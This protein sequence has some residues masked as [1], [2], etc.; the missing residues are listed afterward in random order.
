VFRSAD[1][2]VKGGRKTTTWLA[3]LLALGLGFSVSA[4][5]IV[6]AATYVGRVSG[7]SGHQY[8]YVVIPV[9]V[10]LA[11]ADMQFRLLRRL[12]IRRQT[13]EALL[14]RLG[15]VRGS[16]CWGLDAGSIVSTFRATAASWAVLALALTGWAPVWSGTVY[17]S[18]FVVAFFLTAAP[19]RLLFFAKRA[20]YPKFSRDLGVVETFGRAA[21][22]WSRLASAGL[23]VIALGLIVSA[24]GAGWR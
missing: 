13:P 9:L 11:V 1:P 18:G 6:V 24:L 21:L 7:L 14:S 3:S 22:P 8:R 17:A 4:T 23:T 5:S 19:P 10:A 16:F 20:P 12:M 2:R 15:S